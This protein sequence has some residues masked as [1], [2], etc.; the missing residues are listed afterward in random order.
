MKNN[1]QAPKAKSTEYRKENEK[2]H[3]EESE[4]ERIAKKF[5]IEYIGEYFVIPRLDAEGK[6]VRTHVR[7]WK[8][9]PFWGQNEDGREIVVQSIGIESIIQAIQKYPNEDLRKGATRIE[10][11]KKAKEKEEAEKRAM[12]QKNNLGKST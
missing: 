8:E 3:L 11:E 10:E 2:E 7:A 12:I 5:G 9:I 6:E 1:E 4:G